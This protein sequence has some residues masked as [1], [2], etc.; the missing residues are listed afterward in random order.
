MVEDVTSDTVDEIAK[1]AENA[2]EEQVK[3]VMHTNDESIDEEDKILFI[4]EY[5]KTHEGRS[6][7]GIIFN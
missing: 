1:L 4:A 3:E 7:I 6:I 5:I 2:T